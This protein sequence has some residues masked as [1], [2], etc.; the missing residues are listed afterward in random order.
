MNKLKLS[1]LIDKHG[2][3]TIGQLVNLIKLNEHTVTTFNNVIGTNRFYS[4]DLPTIMDPDEDCAVL[5]H[6]ATFSDNSVLDRTTDY[7]LGEY[8]FPNEVEARYFIKKYHNA[9]HGEIQ[10]FRPQPVYLRSIGDETLYTM[11]LKGEA[12]AVSEPTFENIHSYL[13][14]MYFGLLFRNVD[15]VVKYR[16]W[17]DHLGLP[18]NK[19]ID[20]ASRILK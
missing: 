14:A 15:S 9:K 18:Y 20:E 8:A 5:G 3:I 7:T 1:E 12:I 13:R 17:L 19:V 2:D 16:E 11:N 6:F 10:Y 4:V